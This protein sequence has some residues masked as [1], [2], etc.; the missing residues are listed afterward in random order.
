VANSTEAAAVRTKTVLV[1]DDEAI[2][3]LTASYMFEDLGFEVLEAEGGEQAL[4][5]LENRPDVTL[6]F[7][8]CRMPGMSGPQLAGIA[9][10]RFPHLR[11]VLTSGYSVNVPTERWPLL[12]KPYDPAALERLARELAS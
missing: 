3:R 5:V 6:L 7:T 1:V 9:A 8:D 2:V 11:I 10:D 12:P 4:S